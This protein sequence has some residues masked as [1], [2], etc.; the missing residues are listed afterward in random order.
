MDHYT[1]NRE[2]KELLIAIYK[3]FMNANVI[4]NWKFACIAMEGVLRI[5]HQQVQ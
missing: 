4:H 5:N 2:S 3:E 1:L